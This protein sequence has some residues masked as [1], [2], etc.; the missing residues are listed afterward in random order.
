MLCC[1]GLFPTH[2][3]LHCIHSTLPLW[4]PL[5]VLNGASS[6]LT[7]GFCQKKQEL[8]LH[9]Y[10][11]ES[12]HEYVLLR[13]ALPFHASG[14]CTVLSSENRIP[15]TLIPPL[16]IVWGS[17]Q[18]TG[19]RYLPNIKS[20]D[21]NPLKD[22]LL[23]NI[24][25][26]YAKYMCVLAVC[27]VDASSGYG[28]SYWSTQHKCGWNTFIKVVEI[29]DSRGPSNQ[30]QTIKGR[31]IKVGT[32]RSFE[33]EADKTKGSNLQDEPPLRVCPY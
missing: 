1:R 28:L 10:A 4:G 14:D 13:A 19:A 32:A 8:L 17:L 2:S 15:W 22:I 3:C 18:A 23:V 27:A 6:P 33:K 20:R 7:L 29:W 25:L 9:G 12:Q 21:C 16:L 5:L 26:H 11:A 30:R 24:E 31:G